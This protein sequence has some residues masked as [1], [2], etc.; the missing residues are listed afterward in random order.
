MNLTEAPTVRYAGQQKRGD[1][2]LNGRAGTARTRPGDRRRRDEQI[3]DHRRPL[4]R[5]PSTTDRDAVERDA[6]D[7]DDRLAAPRGVTRR[8]RAL[9]RRSRWPSCAFRTPGRPRRS[10]RSS[11]A[12]DRSAPAC[13]STGRRW[14]SCADDRPHVVGGQVVL[15]DVDAVG[16][17][18]ARDV[19]AIVD[20]DLGAGGLGRPHDALGEFEERCRRPAPCRGAG[21]D[22]RRRAG[23]RW[24]RRPDRGAAR[25]R[26]RRR[27]LRREDGASSSSSQLPANGHAAALD[28]VAGSW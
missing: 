13:A 18:Q 16:A 2:T 17:R 20:D 21:A 6:A 12:R 11:R 25:R 5:P 10:W 3:G 15:A 23:T 1:Y 28:G 4:T 7:G 8:G 27:R 26:R 14:R 24:R 19:G 9:A 22:A